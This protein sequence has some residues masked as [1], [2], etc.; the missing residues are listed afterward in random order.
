MDS[1]ICCCNQTV[2]MPSLIPKYPQYLKKCPQ[3]RLARLAGFL[4]SEHLVGN[5]ILLVN[6]NCMWN[7]LVL[8]GENVDREI[9]ISGKM[10]KLWDM[11]HPSFPHETISTYVRKLRSVDNKISSI[12]NKSH[13]STSKRISN[14]PKKCIKLRHKIL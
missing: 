12:Y 11:I 9:L 3:A 7:C 5:S 14:D 10:L 4:M 6:V 8:R 1:W 13:L 2:V